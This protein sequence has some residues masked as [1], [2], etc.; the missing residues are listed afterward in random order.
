M[1]MLSHRQGSSL[2]ALLIFLSCIFIGA[3]ASDPAVADYR[4]GT[5][6]VRV[7]FFAT[8]ENNRLIETI[9]KD[10]FA[11]VDDGVV[12]RDFRSLHRSDETPLDISVLVDAS[13]S[14]TPRFRET[15]ESVLRLLSQDTAV[16]QISLVT[17]AG[18][19]PAILCS[20]DC[21]TPGVRQQL[22]EMKAGGATPLFDALASTAN[23]ISKR[24]TPGDR[25]VL[26]LF[27]DGNDTISMAS[28][29]QALDAIL[30]S[31]AVLYAVNSESSSALNHGGLLRQM[32]EATGGRSFSMRQGAANTLA[33]VLADLRASYVVTYQ[34]PSHFVGFHSL[35]ILP[36]HD[37]N[38]HF[39]CRRGYYYDEAH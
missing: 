30:A 16:E 21:R 9:N 28:A 26:I 5:S 31:G 35:R 8:D 38:L 15:K 23:L 11:V 32:A 19:K 22:L 1:A 29:G 27:S 13:E 14:V 4:T 3:G 10:D 39:H 34:L 2:V 25:P 37:L 17:F 33:T 36:K 24:H 7:S 20:D 6:E 18:M 12:I